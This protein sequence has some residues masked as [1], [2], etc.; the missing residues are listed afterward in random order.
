MPS[1]LPFALFA[2]FALSST[3]RAQSARLLVTNEDSGD[4][5]VIDLGTDQVIASVSVGKRPRAFASRPTA[6]WRWSP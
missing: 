5:S 2:L 3:A 4:V 6:S 1:R